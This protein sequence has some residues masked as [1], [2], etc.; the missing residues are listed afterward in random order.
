MFDLSPP[1]LVLS[2]CSH[3]VE[4][5]DLTLHGLNG[6]LLM[7]DRVQRRN[8]QTFPRSL[9]LTLED[10]FPCLGRRWMVLLDWYFYC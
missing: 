2:H 1:R 3:E 4:V 9:G 10:V 6:L 7:I 8:G 5:P